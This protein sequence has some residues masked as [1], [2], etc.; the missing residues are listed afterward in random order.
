MNEDDLNAGTENGLQSRTEN[1]SGSDS[2]GRL[3]DR[4]GLKNGSGEDSSY[5]RASIGRRPPAAQDDSGHS[6][7]GEENRNNVVKES[8]SARD[9]T[10]SH[11]YSDGSTLTANNARN[12]SGL[13]H[14]STLTSQYSGNFADD[15]KHSLLQFAL[16][17]FRMAVEQNLVNADGTLQTKDKNKKK[18]GGKH[19]G[20]DWTWKDQVGRQQRFLFFRTSLVLPISR[21]KMDG[22]ATQLHPILL[23]ISIYKS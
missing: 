10:T 14:E 6:S 9:W 20:A 19:N 22:N 18:K 5:Y 1:L 7:E 13:A 15:G 23:G 4:N 17:H 3:V 11:Q 8:H 16:Q 21:F 2:G 12:L